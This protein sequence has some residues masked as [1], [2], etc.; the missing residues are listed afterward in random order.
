MRNFTILETDGFTVENRELS[1]SAQKHEFIGLK[2]DAA[3]IVS[4]A[5]ADL[6]LRIK[7]GLM[8]IALKL[9]QNQNT[10]IQITIDS[11]NQSFWHRKI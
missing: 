1:D 9:W 5:V 6:W 2:P 8:A 10:S 4:A 7:A 3:A 11:F